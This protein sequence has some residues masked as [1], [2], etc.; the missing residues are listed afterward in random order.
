MSK[1]NWSVAI[2]DTI[3]IIVGVIGYMTSNNILPNYAVILGLISF[4]LTTIA[5]VV[6]G[7]QVASLKAQLKAQLKAFTP[8]QNKMNQPK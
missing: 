2:L 4:V 6:F 1:I 7:K 8:Y 3:T 5:A